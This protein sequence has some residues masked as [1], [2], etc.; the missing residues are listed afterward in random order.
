MVKWAYAR[1]ARIF[2][3]P[4]INQYDISPT[5]LGD[6]VLTLE[7]SQLP[8]SLFRCLLTKNF[9]MNKL[10]FEK[11][12]TSQI[13]LPMVVGS[14]RKQ[15]SSR[16]TSTSAS[17]TTLKPLTVWITTNHG[18]F[19]VMGIP[20]HLT[21]LLRHLFAGQ[22]ATIRSEHRT[23]YWFKIGKGV[24]QGCILSPCLLKLYAE[25]IIIKEI[26]PEY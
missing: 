1:N 22:E 24:Q 8:S 12:E 13:Q 6:T 14:W 21:C 26:N 5:F 11:A 2:Q 25:Y 3:Y 17:L 7:M 18:K 16:K 9:Q 23:T 10:G 15:G 20:D 19:L 4:Q